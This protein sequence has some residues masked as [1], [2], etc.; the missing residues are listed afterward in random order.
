MRI[1]SAHHLLGGGVQHFAGLGYNLFLQIIMSV[2]SV[3]IALCYLNAWR[4]T[5]FFS[6]CNL[7]YLQLPFSTEKNFLLTIFYTVVLL[8]SPNEHATPLIRRGVS[9]LG[10]E[11]LLTELCSSKSTWTST[12]N[13]LHSSIDR[14]KIFSI[15][16]QKVWDL[17]E[18]ED[19]RTLRGR[20]K[21][22]F[23]IL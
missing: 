11:P 21:N 22:I 6:S 9:I 13:S 7:E 8:S 12:E 3:F 2:D 1:K 16:F 15:P 23:H 10:I 20:R 17:W 4:D 18:P 14:A 19:R 5:A